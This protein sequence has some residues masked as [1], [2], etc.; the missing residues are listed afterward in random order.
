MFSTQI[1]LYYNGQSGQALSYIYS[2]D[3]NNDATSNDLIYIPET[4]TEINLV[5]IAASGSNPAVTPDEQWAKLDAFIKSDKYL[6]AHRGEYAERNA[7]RSPF[8]HTFDLRIL[9]DVKVKA[10][11]TSNKL[12]VSLDI[13]NLGNLINKEWGHSLYASNQQFSLINY[14]GVVSGNTPTFTYAPSGMTDGGAYS[15]AD[16]SSRW[17]AQI[18]LRYIF[19]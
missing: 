14:R 2:G 11:S 3:M 1:S 8:Q 17:R 4:Q 7:A 13:I 9:Q 10:G 5:T 15:V 6:N 12:Q 19:N 18:G 16:F